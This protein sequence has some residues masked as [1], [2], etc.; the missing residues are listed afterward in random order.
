VKPYYEEAGIMIYHGDCRDVLPSVASADLVLTDPPYGISYVGG[1]GQTVTGDSEPFDPRPLLKYGRC[2]IWG[3]DNFAHLLPASRGWMVWSK[4][5]SQSMIDGRSRMSSAPVELAWSNVASNPELFN[6]YWA[7][8]LNF[9]AS[10]LWTKYHPTQK[11]VALMRWIV[12][13]WT[14]P[15]DLVLDPYMGAGPVAVACKELGRRYIGVEIEE[16][17]CETAVKRL[18][19]ETLVIS[20]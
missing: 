2:V 7:G 10:E 19:Q 8:G 1:T 17:Y 20:A 15:N 3:A 12:D 5:Q 6:H 14:Q 4:I 16:R 18:A 13:R 9:R 11:P